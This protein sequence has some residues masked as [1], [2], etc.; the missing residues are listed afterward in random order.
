M[1]LHNAESC[2]QEGIKYYNSGDAD[3]AIDYFQRALDID[4]KHAPSYAKIA[5]IL[6]DHNETLN[7]MGFWGLAIKNDPSNSEYI[8][9]FVKLI[10]SFELNT[11]N[12]ELKQVLS[13]CLESKNVDCSQTYQAWY[14]L[15]KLDPELKHLLK[16]S[17]QVSHKSFKKLFIRNYE[18]DM[19]LDPFF[20]NGLRKIIVFDY[21]FERFLQGLRRI[22]LEDLSDNELDLTKE[23]YSLISFSLS[24]YCYYTEYIFECTKEEEEK[25]AELKSTLKDTDNSLKE[26]SI[27]ACYK[28]IKDLESIDSYQDSL[29]ED[30]NELQVLE[31]RQ[32][33][34]IKE[35]IATLF[36]IKD[37]TSKKVQEQYEDFPY[38]RWSFISKEIM[39]IPQELF[40]HNLKGNILVAGCGTG[41]EAIELAACYPE[42]DI[43]AI[44]LSLT[45]LSYAI[46][47]AEQNQLD[48]ITFKQSDILDLTDL[49]KKFDFIAS[50]GVLHHMK[51]PLKGWDTLVKLLKPEG[52]M[53]IGLYSKLAR[54][55]II[56]ARE[57]IEEQN[58]KN[59]IAGIRSFRNQAPGMLNKH[60]LDSIRRFRDYYI[61]SECRDLLFHVQEHCYD[62]TDIN[63]MLDSLNLSFTGFYQK[64]KI[65]IE[66]AKTYPEDINKNNL[67][68][69]SNFEKKHQDA[70]VE[71]Y[72]FWCKPN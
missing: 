4:N 40:L 7:G 15:L 53:R 64:Q 58:I 72:R 55:S 14:S 28:H 18:K 8:N 20:L 6:V 36:P 59:D 29:P 38:P 1:K 61:L 39:D 25:I 68:N 35:N 67:I 43:L 65:L 19:L 63:N 26:I 48:N 5:Q 51:E 30:V 45:S 70:F 16:A 32:M 21:D 50:S 62:L 22:L 24:Q 49:D 71:M 66:Y 31:P 12:P 9:N 27:Y 17:H 2:Y 44:D 33:Y 60:T 3:E 47:R 10:R 46:M 41:R 34:K 37:K 56:E 11:F 23:E 52:T 42:C 69:W 57:V 54:E 13:I